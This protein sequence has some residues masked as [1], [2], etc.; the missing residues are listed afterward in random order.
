M[1]QLN[2]VSGKTIIDGTFGGGGYSAALLS[3][4]AACVVGIDQD[5]SALERA[6]PL[7]EKYGETLKLAHA[8]FSAMTKVAQDHDFE[9]VDAVV[10]DLGI[11]SD[12]L[13]DPARGL[14]FRADGPLD[15]RLDGH[16]EETAADVLN[17]YSEAALVDIFRKYGEEPK[18]RPLAKRIVAMRKEA[19]WE[20]TSQLLKLIEQFYP[21][22]FQQRAH[23]AGR[24]FQALRIHINQELSALEEVLPQAQKLLKPGGKLCV[25]TFHSLE[26]RLVKRYFRDQCVAPVDEIGRQIG[27]AP[28]RQ[29]V[30]K[31][32]PTQ[33][34]I[35]RNPRSKSAHLRVLERV[36]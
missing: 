20:T 32:A 1:A 23:P 22:R 13:D 30:R 10:L 17:T 7:Q 27:E 2:D 15:M 12:Q 21:A 25:V 16:G 4:G 36:S 33:E 26:D 3:A 18:A 8:N 34:E 6:K 19:L 14:S 11:S 31:V 9:E 35:E 28:Y 24:I 5:A 29:P